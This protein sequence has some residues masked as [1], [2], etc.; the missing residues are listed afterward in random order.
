M[1][2]VFGGAYQGKTDYARRVLGV[3][4]LYICDENSP[5]PMPS[6]GDIQGIFGINGLHMYILGALRRGEDPAA[7][8]HSALPA[9]QNAVILCDDITGG[10]VPTDALLRRWREATGQALQLLSRHAQ[11]VVRIHCGIG[12]TLKGE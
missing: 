1:T 10:V 8:L 2:V 9:L 12:Q 6:E 4:S 7:K 5:L 3:H 11:T